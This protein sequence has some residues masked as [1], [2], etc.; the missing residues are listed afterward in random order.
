[1]DQRDTP[2]RDDDLKPA[3]GTVGGWLA[4]HALS[5]IVVGAV[6]AFVCV[7][8]D[9][10]TVA[11][12]AVGLGLVIF[13]H[14]LGHFAAAKWCDVHVETFSIGFGPPLPGC[15]FRKGET[16]YQIAL[17]P[18]GGYVK[19]VGEGN[20]EDGED[21]PRSFKN[22]SV[23]QRMVIISAGVV[24]NILL[25]AVCFVGV[26]MTTGVDRPAGVIGS[27][28]AGSPAW[29]K[30]LRPG[31]QL[32][33]IG[34]SDN[35][36]FDDVMPEVMH[37]KPGL[38]IPVKYE[39]F[40]GGKATVVETEV[41][42]RIN[43]DRGRPMIGIAPTSAATLLPKNRRNV[44]PYAPD[45]PAA[46]AVPP[47]QN[48]DR[49]VGATDPNQ[50]ADKYN[51]NLTTNLADDPRA[52]G[53]GRHD[54]FD[55]AGRMTQLAGK[56]IVLL[57]RHERAPEDTTPEDP[58]PTA[59]HIPPAFKTSYGL[60]LGMGPITALREDSAAAKHG[61]LIRTP[62]ET[63]DT[64]FEVE[65]AD[66]DGT[67]RRYV[68]DPGPNP[69]KGVEALD[70]YRLPDQLRQ[71]AAR[72]GD[73]PKTVKLKLKRKAGHNEHGQDVALELPWDDSWRD[74]PSAPSSEGSPRASD[75]L[76]L[77]YAVKT[78][79]DFVRPDSPAAKAVV[80]THPSGTSVAPFFTWVLV[81]LVV[82]L[83]ALFAHQQIQTLRTLPASAD[84]SPEDRRYVRRQAWQRLTGCAIVVA[85]VAVTSTWYLWGR[86][87]GLERPGDAVQ[88]RRA[89][90]DG[91]AAKDSVYPLRKG[92]VIKAVRLFKNS[93]GKPTQDLEVELGQD[94]GAH[95]QW[96]A[97]EVSSARRLG[98]VVQ[99]GEDEKVEVL[100]DGDEDAGRPQV[101]RGIGFDSDMRL[102][103]ADT[104]GQAVVMGLHYTGRLISRIYQN[105]AAMFT[106]RISFPKNASGPIDIGAVAYAIA[107]QSFP[108]FVL[109][110]GMI[111]VNLAVINF[112]PI[113]IL[114]GGHMVFLIYEKLRGRPA[115][116]AIRVAA[117]FIGLAMIGSLMA[118]VL[119]LD[120]QKRL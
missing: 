53:G 45:S 43:K 66:P 72:A 119:F 117:T 26:Y 116:E 76:G 68:S 55:L 10:I 94:Q 12:V 40:A 23:G 111:S 54:Y 114:D 70:P 84:L 2:E 13:I 4:Q 79:I 91:P 19:M 17:V 21:D 57:V 95:A 51:P 101:A 74:Q 113:P 39:S 41:V 46:R 15:R 105:L 5:L 28:D 44:P 37:W 34:G 42:P 49:I 90:G 83:A 48:G 118:F 33:K 64:I 56:E 92:D 16:V 20:E 27:V 80:S 89:A 65:V 71:W 104:P 35:P 99:R 109:F 100:M 81:A 7:R 58:A 120:V 82:G 63:G 110:I 77:A 93:D 22:K 85:I 112:L 11:L 61:I 108:L 25:A 96:L 38:P 24:M 50:P 97:E 98:L 32:L 36:L 60:R 87:G 62:Q 14:E 75:G 103:K 86:D 88:A 9:P 115:P 106:G 73:G 67:V 78:Q 47:L 29:Q 107:D 59:V 1:V 31:V 69:P 18:L 8:L 3:P 6:V 102:E 52:P 30:G